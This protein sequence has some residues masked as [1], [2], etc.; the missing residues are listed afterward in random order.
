MKKINLFSA[1]IIVIG[2]TVITTSCKKN[3]DIQLEDKVLS[4]DDAYAE[5]TYENVS[6]MANEAYDMKTGNL[7]SADW[8]RIFLSE[9]ATVTMDTNIFPRTLTIDFGDVNC[10]CNDGRYRRGKIDITFTGKYREPG[11]IITHG[12]ENYFVN[13][14][15]VGGSKVVTN[16]G[17]NENGNL[18]FTIEVT[19][20]IQKPDSSGT[21]TWNSSRVRE[22]IQG[23]DTPNRWD[24]IYLVTGTAN[25][26]RPNGLTWEREIMTPLRVELACRFIV[27]GTVELHP[28]GRPVSLLDYGNGD[29]DNIATFTMNGK[30]YTIHLH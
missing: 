18:N 14:K 15:S 8:N 22:W 27:S 19:G 25:G 11:T 4:Q 23:S 21:F 20:I 3:N 24:D 6:D 1:L 26:A 13:D 16:M 10:L 7:K 29:C 12:F 9:C 28:E 2:L 30:T 17:L 5:S